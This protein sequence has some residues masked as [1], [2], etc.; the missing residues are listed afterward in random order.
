[1]KQ[2]GTIVAIIFALFGALTA[3]VLHLAMSSL[4]ATMRWANSP[5]LGDRVTTS[6]VLG[7]I[8]G[9]CLAAG[10]Y[11]WMTT[12]SFVGETIVELD[13]VHWPTAAET[14]VNAMVVIATSVIAAVIIGC[15]DL[16]FAQLSGALAKTNWTF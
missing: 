15:Y 4:M 3:Y 10:L 7:V 11:A 6:V 9:A 2:K 12:R 5:L 1:M 8:L 16:I 14:R 13:K